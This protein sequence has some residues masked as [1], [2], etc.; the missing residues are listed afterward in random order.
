M[1]IKHIIIGTFNNIFK[2][3]NHIVQPR[4]EICNKCTEKKYI[5]GM[6]YICK[7]CG[8][9]LKSKA[10]VLEETCPVGKW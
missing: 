7:Q 5:F 8:C 1:K 4:L 2:K 9:V 6:G 10:T 3:N